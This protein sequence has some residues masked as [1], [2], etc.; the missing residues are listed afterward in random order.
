METGPDDNEL[1]F[2][3]AYAR[4]TVEVS[5]HADKPEVTLDAVSE[6]GTDISFPPGPAPRSPTSTSCVS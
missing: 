5:G 3:K 6:R 2:G 4:G 1:Y